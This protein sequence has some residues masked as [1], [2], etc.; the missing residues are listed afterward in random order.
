MVEI[1]AVDLNTLM[2]VL[3]V[4]RALALKIDDARALRELKA[5]CEGLEGLIHSIDAVSP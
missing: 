5:L 1:D 2:K 4:S 3:F